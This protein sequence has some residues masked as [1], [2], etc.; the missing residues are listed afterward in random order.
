MIPILYEKT[1]TAF[2]SNGLGRLRDCISAL[3]VEERNSIYELDFE[4]PVT[5]ANY[6]L[7]QVG[8]IVAVTHDDTADV[9]PFDIVSFSKPINGIVTFHCVHISYRQSY[10]TV[11]GTNINS[12]SDA[13]T[14]L[15]TAEPTNPFTY[16]T[17]KTSSGY[18]A[19]ADGIPRSVRS[20]LGGVEGSILD[21]YGGEYEWD[22]FNVILHS[23]RGT[24]RNF[25][26]RYGVNMLEYNEDYDISETYS[27]C[28]PYWTDGEVTIVGDKQESGSQTITGRGECIP[29]DVSDKF[30][31]QP[32][33]AEVEAMALSLMT[34]NNVTIPKQNIH[35]SFV[36]LQDMSEYEGVSPLL[37]CSLCD[38]IRVIFPDYGTSGNFKIVKTTWNVLNDRFDEMELGDLSV[39]LAEALG[40]N[41]TVSGPS[42]VMLEATGKTGIEIGL[43]AKNTT[44]NYAVLFG[45]GSGGSNHGVFSKVLN[46]WLVYSNGTDVFVNNVNIEQP[47]TSSTSNRNTSNQTTTNST[48][49]LQVTSLSHKTNT[50]KYLVI[51]KCAYKTSTNTSNI[52]VNCAGTQIAYEVT[53]DTVN[54]QGVIFGVRTTTKGATETVELR[55]TPQSGATATLPAYNTYAI[56]CVDILK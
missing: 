43:T 1:E 47:N 46:K 56:T 55:L 2:V 10:L 31:S 12:L 40:I 53:S 25:D 18:L 27:A 37:R 33:K 20:M 5:G 13:F 32:T 48:T 3:V 49:G 9:Q 17:D 14:L 28:I 7:I 8:R 35:V 21:A 50:G 52:R 24:F 51:A 36:R 22:K 23:A 42:P 38:T 26:I 45:I 54:H 30:E 44:N 41:N 34:R 11:A 39:T 4:Y 29:L 16:T 19:A 15:G 6:D